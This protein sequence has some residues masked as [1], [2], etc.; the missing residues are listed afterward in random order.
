M[1]Q[2]NM[3]HSLLNKIGSLV[4]AAVALSVVGG[5][6]FSGRTGNDFDPS[7]VGRALK[8]GIARQ[9]DVRAALGM[10]SGTGSAIM[11]FHDRPHLTWT[12]LYERADVDVV[13]GKLDDH[14]KY[15][16]VFFDGDRM[17]S[18]LWFISDME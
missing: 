9:A 15:L 1:S 8:P 18:Y 14:L 11:P 7:V 4:T 12:Y 13:S 5:C 10:P 2:T 6:T 17:D 16:F 3:T